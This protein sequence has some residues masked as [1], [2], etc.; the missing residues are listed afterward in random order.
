MK[1]ALQ[2]QYIEHWNRFSGEI[3][4]RLAEF[5]R[6]PA[7]EYLWELLYCLLTPQSRAAHAEQAI[8]RLREAGFLERRFD[9]TATLRDPASYIR[10]HNQK[11]ARL[12]LAV[13]QREG[14]EAMLADAT[15]DTQARRR[16]LVDRI[17]G[18]GWKEASH[19]LRNIGHLDLAIID[20]HILKHMQRCGALQTI[21]R[22]I[23]TRRVYLDLESRF[24]RLADEAGL[25]P[26]ELDLLF[27]S[28]EEGSVRK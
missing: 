8:A 4:A 7:E 22:G 2:G 17:N 19:F 23:G 5:T 1:T 10:F 3:R 9:P 27:W 15:L 14:I 16:W 13:D 6:V 18:L 24:M 20:R 25:R 28:Y 11:A 26:Q 21:P 12:L